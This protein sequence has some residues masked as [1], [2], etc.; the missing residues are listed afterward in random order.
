MSAFATPASAPFFEPDPL[1]RDLLAVSLTA[2]NLLRPCYSVTG[3]LDDFAPEYFNPAAQ[4]M[5]GLP[6]RPI[7]TARTLFPDIFTNGIFTF[8][9]QVFET[10]EPDNFQRYTR[11]TASIITSTSRPAAAGTGC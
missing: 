8:Y 10:D 5:T 4:R 7:G 3:E 9:R 6:E 1:L 11:P 2:I